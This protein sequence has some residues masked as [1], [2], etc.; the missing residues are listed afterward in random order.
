M[1]FYSQRYAGS[2][3]RGSYIDRIEEKLVVLWTR[4]STIYTLN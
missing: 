3:F 1:G 2:L 4:A